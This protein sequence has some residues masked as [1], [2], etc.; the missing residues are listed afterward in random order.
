MGV[1]DLALKSNGISAF[2]AFS[3]GLDNDTFC[4]EVDNDEPPPPTFPLTL[5]TPPPLLLPSFNE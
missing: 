1:V 3:F 5:P 4:D 2:G